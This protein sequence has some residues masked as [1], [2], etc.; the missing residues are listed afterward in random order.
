MILTFK[1]G[2]SKTRIHINIQILLLRA[3]T[4]DIINN[5]TICHDINLLI[6]CN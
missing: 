6:L 1:D 5:F 4:V 3:I 2:K